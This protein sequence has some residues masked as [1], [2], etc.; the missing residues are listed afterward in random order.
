ML[1]ILVIDDEDKT[2]TVLIMLLE[3][4]G[5]MVTG[6]STATEALRRINEEVYDLVITDL[7]LDDMSG[8][9]ILKAARQ[10]DPTMEVI[11]LTGY[12]TV[13]SAV[14]AMKLG[15]FDYIK[16]PWVT[17][18][19]LM[20]VERALSRKRMTEEIERLRDRLRRER[21]FD[22]IVAESEE[23]KDVL[24]LVAKV[25]ESDSP[26]ML[27]G[28][29]GTGKELL[30]RAIHSTGR[31][32]GPFVPINCGALPETLL[33]S[34]LFGYMRGAFTGA[35]SNKKGL[36]EEAHNGTLFMDE[37]GDMSTAVQVKLLRALDLG[38]IRRVGSNTQ[39]YVDVRLVTATN[40]DIGSL[41]A[42]GR[43]REELYYRLNVI[44]V[45]IP[46]LRDRR[47]D[48]IPLAEH[49]LK[50]YSSRMNKEAM[51]ISPEARQLMLKHDWP[52][53]VRELENAIERAVVLARQD[54]LFPEDLPFSDQFQRP[55]IL[56][57]ASRGEWDLK[58]LE[59]EYIL[60]VLAD[61]SDN[62]SQ[63]AKRLGIA[64]NTLWRKL[65]EYDIS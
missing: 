60:N 35:T 65:K 52:G 37:I 13:E 30:A 6:V 24:E 17:D 4:H 14:E 2:R 39:F 55:N 64:R 36:F 40:K 38:E 11:V 20:R 54:T 5:Y 29:S 58:K 50:M 18:E 61:C 25:A 16:K 12:G 3:E 9:D 28:E 34:E 53:N 46:P 62:H 8:M 48:I 21:N 27:Q 22:T 32:D 43:F 19:L 26:I 33:E 23:M 63:A 59:Q 47:T 49:F 56:R 41:V 57:Q 45:F 1:S 44:Y 7:K 31:P 15:A 10:A 51:D 42:E